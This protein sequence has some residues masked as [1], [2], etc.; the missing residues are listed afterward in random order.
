MRRG[1]GNVYHG[2]N[3]PLEETTTPTDGTHKRFSSLSLA[4]VLRGG[5]VVEMT[6]EPG[7]LGELPK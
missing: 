5:Q 4:A 3:L 1:G 6:A 2:P 7:S